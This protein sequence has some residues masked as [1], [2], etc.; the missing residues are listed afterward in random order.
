MKPAYIVA[1]GGSAYSLTPL[2]KFFQHTA[3][4]RVSYV[5]LRHVGTGARSE[6]LHIL[7][8]HSSLDV[9]LVEEGMAMENDMVY[10]LPQG[11]Y[12]TI[13]DSGFHL[14]KR[15]EIR[16]CAIDVF[17]KSL[18]TQYKSK[19][20]GVLLSGSNNNGTEGIISIKH[21]GGKVIVQ[22]PSSCQF[23]QMPKTA[24]RSGCVDIVALPEQMPGLIRK[25][26]QN[27]HYNH[28]AANTG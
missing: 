7:Q 26:I 18:A 21:A 6:L 4:G 8:K 19:T 13:D 5:V 11:Y 28:L 20:F 9:K 17:M 1:I 22:D 25:F 10:L 16:N 2:I 24:I 15:T 27:P 12:M 23:D 3:S 14:K